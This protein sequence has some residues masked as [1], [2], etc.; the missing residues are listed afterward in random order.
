M[1][2]AARPSARGLTIVE[3]AISIVLVGVVLTAALQTVGMTRRGHLTMSD[4]ARGQ[5]LALDLLNEALSQDYMDGTP[6]VR[7][8]GLEVG[9]S[10]ANRSQFTDVDDYNGWSETPPRDRSGNV[11]TGTTGWLRGVRVDWVEPKTLLATAQ[12]DSGLKLV[13]VTA[14]RGGV[15]ARVAGYRSI[16]WVE[17]IPTPTD[18]TA[19]H[20]PT[21][22]AVA[23]KTTAV[24]PL[25][26]TL[27]ATG[28]SDRDSDSLSYVWDFGDGTADAAGAIV[29]HTYTVVG[30][31]T[32]TLTVYDGRGGVG[33]ASVVLTVTP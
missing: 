20:A 16:A 32:V 12:P 10:S 2:R 15:V 21:G 13:T 33:S 31:Y 1:S 22:S 27:D 8:F 11:L 24:T 14:T 23:S 7:V 6:A 30:T 25:S 17:A 29:S 28:S 3:A 5:Q 9:K 19:N 18:A 4:R 26:T